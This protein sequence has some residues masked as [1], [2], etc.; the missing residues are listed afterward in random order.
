MTGI[1]ED[2]KFEEMCEDDWLSVA[3]EE[4]QYSLFDKIDSNQAFMAPPEIVAQCLD[5]WHLNSVTIDIRKLQEKFLFPALQIDAEP[6][7]TF[8][9]RS[10][11]I[12]PVYPE[13]PAIIDF[14]KEWPGIGFIVDTD[15]I[16]NTYK[17][18]LSASVSLPDAKKTKLYKHLIKIFGK[19]QAEIAPMLKETSNYTLK[20][21]LLHLIRMMVIHN[22]WNILD[23]DLLLDMLVWVE[24]Y[25][26]Y[27][28]PYA[29]T[30]L[31]RLKVLTHSG[32]AIYSVAGNDREI[33]R[34][35]SR[36]S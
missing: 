13:E 2:K 16:R 20:H 17:S 31:T 14:S 4:I 30:M 35:H 22:R 25:L 3:T 36:S 15:E 19:N 32:N 24:D 7:K 9:N 27:E 10:D 1:F 21:R 23:L 34:R 12:S 8:L 29:M 18:R 11:F 26:V 28:S 6:E 5:L 33:K